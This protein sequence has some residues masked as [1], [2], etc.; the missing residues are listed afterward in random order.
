MKK[1]GSSKSPGQDMDTWDLP[2]QKQLSSVCGCHLEGK[3][4]R[5]RKADQGL[6]SEGTF[7]FREKLNG[8]E[9]GSLGKKPVYLE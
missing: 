6:K 2:T 1:R 4:C 5:H 3:E 7:A 9:T 8:Y